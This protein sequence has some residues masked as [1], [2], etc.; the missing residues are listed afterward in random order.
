MSLVGA[1]GG[2]KA[3]LRNLRLLLYRPAHPERQSCQRIAHAPRR[4]HVGVQLLGFAAERALQIGG[5][6]NAQS[7]GPIASSGPP[8]LALEGHTHAVRCSAE[9]IRERPVQQLP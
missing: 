7:R 1:G 2:R 6:A 3:S 8:T 9:A 5:E 4:G